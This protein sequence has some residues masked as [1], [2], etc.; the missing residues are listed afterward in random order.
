MSSTNELP[1]KMFEHFYSTSCHV[2]SNTDLMDNTVQT[3]KIC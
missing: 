2:M 1:D 3:F